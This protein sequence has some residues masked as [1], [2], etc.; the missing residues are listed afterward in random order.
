MGR[1]LLSALA[2]REF[3]AVVVGVAQRMLLPVLLC[4]KVSEK[5]LEFGA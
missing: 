4:P 3:E 2:E 5:G 1:D